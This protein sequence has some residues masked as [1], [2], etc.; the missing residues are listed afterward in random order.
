MTNHP[1]FP[2]YKRLHQQMQA[3]ATRW[4][5]A[6]GDYGYRGG[7]TMVR[8]SDAYGAGTHPYGENIEFY[9]PY[10]DGIG[11]QGSFSSKYLDD[12]STLEADSK[13]W[14]E[15]E[16]AEKAAKSA[17]ISALEMSPDVQAYKAAI[18]TPYGGLN[19]QGYGQFYPQW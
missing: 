16:R 9:A 12:D 18:Q 5:L 17:R 10:V 3:L 1:D 19:L 14:Y 8:F 13:A 6:W 11:R 2:A 15:A 4:V 7:A